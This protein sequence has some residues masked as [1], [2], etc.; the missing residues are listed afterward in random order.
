[1]CNIVKHDVLGTA[2]IQ[3]IRRRVCLFLHSIHKYPKNTIHSLPIP[4]FANDG[5]KKD[6]TK[7]VYPYLLAI[8]IRSFHST[9]NRWKSLHIFNVSLCC[10]CFIVRMVCRASECVCICRAVQSYRYNQTNSMFDEET[11]WNVRVVDW[12]RLKK[13]TH[14]HTVHAEIQIEAQVDGYW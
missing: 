11:T 3:F 4:W 6:K 8:V 14:T 12:R 9:V 7:S 5:N 10:L 2:F 1:M 13:D